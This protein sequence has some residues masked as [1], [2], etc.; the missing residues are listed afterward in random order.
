LRPYAT[1]QK[2]AGLIPDEDIGFF[3]CYNP[4]SCT[5]ALGSTKHLTEICTGIFLGVKGS[6]LACKAASLAAI[7][8][9]IVYKM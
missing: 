5:V 4:S 6:Y 7:S 3:K 9:P 2:V 8:E 1:S